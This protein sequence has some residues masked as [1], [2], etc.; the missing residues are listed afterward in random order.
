MKW[1]TLLG[2]FLIAGS[3]FALVFWE[4]KGREILLLSPIL[5]A[6]IDIKEGSIIRQ[7]D[8]R[9]S[10]VLPENILLG[11]LL[12]QE[13]Q[14]LIGLVANCEIF[15]NQQLLRSYFQKENT[16]LKQGESLFVL[17]DA[18]IH[19]MSSAVRAGDTIILYSLPEDHHL[20]QYTVAFVKDRNRKEVR[21]V[22]GHESDLLKRADS[23]S[24]VSHLEIICT[25][26]EYIMICNVAMDSGF[27]NLLVVLKG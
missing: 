24:E 1:K 5:T 13:Q 12:P 15:S 3:L 2:I 7:E 20:G 14:S 26:E 16:I 8:L 19:S 25:L 6:E 23:T 22:L 27:G 11:A 21:D 10:K 9:V 18:W 4:V 17:P